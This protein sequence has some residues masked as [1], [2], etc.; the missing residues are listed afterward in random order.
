M[1]PNMNKS[2]AYRDLNIQEIIALD[3]PPEKAIKALT[4]SKYLERAKSLLEEKLWPEAAMETP[5]VLSGFM[6]I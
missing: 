1:P 2:K 5:Y 3:L 4:A 6:Q